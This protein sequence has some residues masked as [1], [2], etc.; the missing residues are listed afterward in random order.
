M[1]NKLM[2][3]IQ[4]INVPSNIRDKEIDAQQ[5]AKNQNVPTESKLPFSKEALQTQS[6][7]KK[8]HRRKRNKGDHSSGGSSE[9][10]SSGNN[11]G[12]ESGNE[13]SSGTIEKTEG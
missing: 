6:P 2:N 12:T 5:L 1:K 9:E 13:E 4:G 3:S 10:Y 7:K 11:S 8:K